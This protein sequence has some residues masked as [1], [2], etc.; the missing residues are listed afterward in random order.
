MSNRYKIDKDML[1]V[2]QRHKQVVLSSLVPLVM[3]I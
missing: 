1:G 2:L 3:N